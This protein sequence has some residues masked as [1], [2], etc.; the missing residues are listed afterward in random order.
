MKEE[1]EIFFKPFDYVREL[2]AF[3][4]NKEFDELA[5]ELGVREWHSVVWIG[6]FFTLDSDYGEHWFDNWELREEKRFEANNLGIEDDTLMIVD[7][8]RFKM[9]EFNADGPCHKDDHIKQFW[10]DILK[11]MTISLK[12]L[13]DEARQNKKEIEEAGDTNDPDFDYIKDLEERIEKIK[14]S[15]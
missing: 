3:I 4:I 2:D 13:A 15:S 1:T 11:S 10:T 9:K 14:A 8:S 12:T 7:P 6:R 5:K